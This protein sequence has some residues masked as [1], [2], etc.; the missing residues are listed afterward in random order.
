MRIKN[1]SEIIPEQSINVISPNSKETIKF[2]LR[3]FHISSSNHA[4]E[5]HSLW[6]DDS[7]SWQYTPLTKYVLLIRLYL[8]V[9]PMYANIYAVRK[10][11]GTVGRCLGAFGLNKDNLKSLSEFKKW[12]NLHMIDVWDEFIITD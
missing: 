4:N 8:D 1:F 12:L 9:S 5:T 6:V 7:G 3:P 10:G 11:G 2:H